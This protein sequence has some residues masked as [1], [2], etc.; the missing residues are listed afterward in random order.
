MAQLFP[1]APEA[2][3]NTQMIAKRCQVEIQFNE[4]KLPVYNVPEGFTAPEYL[5]MLCNQGLYERYPE[6]ETNETRKQEL[7]TRLEYEIG[8]IESMGFVDY[9]LIVGTY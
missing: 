7:L 9:F 3:T 6:I 5:R 8:V 4:R 1:Y 2:L